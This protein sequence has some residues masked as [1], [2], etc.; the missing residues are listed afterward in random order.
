M[1]PDHGADPAHPFYWRRELEAYRSGLLT[2]GAG[3]LAAPHCYGVEERPDGAVWLWL[4][5]VR[6]VNRHDVDATMRTFGAAASF[7]LNAEPL[8]GHAAE[9]ALYA[10]LMR[11]SP[12]IRIEVTRRHASD[13]AVVLEVVIR[14]AQRADFRG[15][16]S[17]GRT[18]EFP[19]YAVGLPWSH[20]R[21]RPAAAWSRYGP[22]C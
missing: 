11:A 4:E 6:D 9:T 10:E 3:G 22:K 21:L 5:D 1:G 12:D 14:G 18:A 16:L 8:P 17:M 7:P 19:L 15:I 20:R 13:E 2:E